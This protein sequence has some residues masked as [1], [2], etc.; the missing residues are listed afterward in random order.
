[1]NLILPRH[2]DQSIFRSAVL[3]LFILIY[4]R[5]HV[6]HVPCLIFHAGVLH[7]VQFFIGCDEPSTS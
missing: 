6:E 5:L 3:F 1:M 4:N 2:L 7:V